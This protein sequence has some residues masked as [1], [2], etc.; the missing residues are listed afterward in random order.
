M[1]HTQ[2]RLIVKKEL[3]AVYV[4]SEFTVKTRQVAQQSSNFSTLNILEV[5]S[6]FGD[7]LIGILRGIPF[8]P[9][10]YN[11]IGLVL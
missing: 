4:L 3:V 9:H 8:D 6:S 1:L 11:T 5:V 10:V 2:S 7:L